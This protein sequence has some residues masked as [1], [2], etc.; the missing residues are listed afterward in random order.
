MGSPRDAD[1]TS[2][3]GTVTAVSDDL[4]DPQVNDDPYS[5]FGALRES[6]PVHW[7]ERFQ[8]WIVTRYADIQWINL[9]PEIFSS[10]VPQLDMRPPYPPI[11]VSDLDAYNFV[12]TQQGGRIITADPPRHRAMRSSLHRYFTPSAVEN[13]RP[14]VRDAITQL[15]GQLSSRH[16]DVVADFAVP[17][18]LLVISEL[19]N[20]P[21]EDR[22]YIRA[23]AENLL[24]GPRVSPSRMREI[25]AAMEAMSTYMEPLVEQ[26]LKH[27]GEDLISRLCE[28]ESSGAF[29]REEVLQNIAFLVVAGHETT[30]NLICN[31]LLALVRHPDQWEMLRADPAGLAATTTEECLRYDPPV[32]SIERIAL[33]DA[34]LGGKRIRAMDRV[35][36]I[37]AAGNRD[38]RRFEDPDRFDITRPNNKHLSF[39]HGI[40]TCLGAALTRV[41]GEETFKAFGEKFGNLAL[42]TE[43]IEHAAALHLRSLK[44]L[45]I[46]WS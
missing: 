24:I 38:P 18:P 8:V 33:I 46:S 32:K 45:E 31:G 43:P 28:A 19:L 42:L 23:T 3:L 10:S 4:F 21:V 11:D 6:D 37:I 7:N 1:R 26:R 2:G 36:W 12:Q 41:E 16:M 30:I 14:L 35:R 25:A 13:W 5:Y 22:A 39:G 17:F 34:E 15:L 44:A 29:T 9:H 40:H 20:I 27:P